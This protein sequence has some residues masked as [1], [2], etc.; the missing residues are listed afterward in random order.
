MRNKIWQFVFIAF[1]IWL[2]DQL[3]L[4]QPNW[5]FIAIS[6]AVLIIV[7]NVKQIV[8]KHSKRFWPQFI[9]SPILFHLAAVFFSSILINQVLIQF[10]FLIEAGFLFVYFKNIY[11]YL[12]FGAP[13]R[14]MKLRKLLLS[15]S[16]LSF[17]AAASF[18]YSLPIFLNLS[19]WL[20][21]CL[22]IFLVFL[23]FVQ[24]LIFIANLKEREELLFLGVNTLILAELAGVLLLLPLNYGVRGL[25]LALIFYSLIL[26][27]NWRREDRLDLKSLRWPLIIGT[28]LILIILLSARWL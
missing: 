17:F 13:E 15:A 21:F 10:V 25:L 14:E 28:I 26:F 5:F 11:Y 9:L 6:A 19:F 24:L 8:V 20:I 2:L 18:L 4:F 22:F 27:N 1:L 16:F 3:F 12:A 23:F 7:I